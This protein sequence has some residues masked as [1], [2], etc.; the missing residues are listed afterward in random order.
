MSIYHSVEP[1]NLKD[2]YTEYDQVSFDLSLDEGRAYLLNSIRLEGELQVYEGSAK[3]T[4]Q[5]V[6]MDCKIGAHSLFESLSVETN[7]GLIEHIADYPRV[8]KQRADATLCRNDMFNSKYVSELRSGDD[9]ITANVLRGFK[10][11][12]G[13]NVTS[14]SFSPD[15]S[16][17]PDICLNNALGDPLLSAGKV[18]SLRLTV[19]LNRVF[20]ALF[21]AVTSNT[22]YQVKD[23]RVCF[24]SLPSPSNVPSSTPS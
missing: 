10:T 2:N 6:K 15:F 12:V 8:V 13:S 4:T 16:L 17:V 7:A 9:E 3:I 22:S 1:Q 5:N 14:E 24:T 23:F 21:G 18:G 19:T 20:N 11:L